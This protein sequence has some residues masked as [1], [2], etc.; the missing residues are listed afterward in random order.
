[1]EPD[2]QNLARAEMGAALTG[3]GEKPGIAGAVFLAAH[4]RGATDHKQLPNVPVRVCLAP[5]RDGR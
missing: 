2:L 3:L 4:R 1:M 5:G